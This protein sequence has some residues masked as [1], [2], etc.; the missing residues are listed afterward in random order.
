MIVELC[1]FTFSMIFPSGVSSSSAIESPGPATNAEHEQEH[2][3][4]RRKRAISD[5]SLRIS[6]RWE[7]K[8]EF[9][10]SLRVGRLEPVKG[11]ASAQAESRLI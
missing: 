4:S 9:G 11:P 10:R 7:T 2:P 3:R 5:S 6:M 8:L 1:L